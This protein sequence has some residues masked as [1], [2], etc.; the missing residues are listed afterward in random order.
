M[1]STQ[2]LMLIDNYIY[3]MKMWLKELQMISNK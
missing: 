3:L 2:I 1:D